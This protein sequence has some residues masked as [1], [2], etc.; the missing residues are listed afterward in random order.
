MCCLQ[1]NKAMPQDHEMA[2]LPENWVTPA[3]PFAYVA[4]DYFG[5]Y[6]KKEGHNEQKRCGT[7]FTCL[8]RR[9]IH[10]EVAC[11]LKT[12]CFLYILWH[13]IALHSPAPSNNRTKFVGAETSAMWNNLFNGQQ[14]AEALPD[15]L[16]IQPSCCKPP[17]QSLAKTNCNCTY[18]PWYTPTWTQKSFGWQ[19]LSYLNKS[20]VNARLLTAIWS[21]PRYPFLL[22]RNQ[23]LTMKTSTDLPL[24]QSYCSQWKKVYTCTYQGS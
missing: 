16:E 7:L 3:L 8:V 12:D 15:W 10:I 18:N 21:D 5:P 4:E 20:V 6:F 11:L 17:G 9:A 23:I 24:Q 22:S 19:I 14:R 1:T 2:D 13:V